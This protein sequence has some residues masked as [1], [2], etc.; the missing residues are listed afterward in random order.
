MLQLE[1][2]T[3]YSFYLPSAGYNKNMSSFFVQ[4]CLY[5]KHPRWTVAAFATVCCC[6]YCS[7]LKL[8]SINNN[9]NNKQTSKKRTIIFFENKKNQLKSYIFIY[10]TQQQQQQ[11][12]LFFKPTNIILAKEKYWEKKDINN[13]CH[14]NPNILIHW[15]FFWLLLIFF[16]YTV[17]EIPSRTNVIIFFI[18]VIVVIFH[19]IVCHGDR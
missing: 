8:L 3:E 7:Q 18:I 11:Q 17:I 5:L 1:W 10:K 4:N 2:Q 14:L 12:C 13:T 16:G 6:F 19:N 9:N 15:R